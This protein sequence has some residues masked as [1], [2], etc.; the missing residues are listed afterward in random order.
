MQADDEHAEF[1]RDADQFYAGV[2]ARRP[3]PAPGT[4]RHVSRLDLNARLTVPVRTDRSIDAQE[5]SDNRHL[6]ELEEQMR[7]M[8]NEPAQ[9]A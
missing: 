4:K 8:L 9:P 1:V 5:R 2:Q 7:E 6:T 3:G